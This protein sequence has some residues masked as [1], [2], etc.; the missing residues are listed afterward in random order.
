VPPSAGDVITMSGATLSI[1]NGP[2][3]MP[4]VQLPATS[5]TAPDAIMTAAIGRG[6]LRELARRSRART[7]D[8]RSGIADAEHRRLGAS[9]PAG[10]PRQRAVQT[11]LLTPSAETVRGRAGAGS[12]KAGDR[13]DG[14]ARAVDRRDV[15]PTGDRIV[16]GDAPHDPRGDVPAVLAVERGELTSRS[17]AAVSASGCQSGSSSLARL[18]VSRVWALPSAFIT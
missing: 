10:V 11:T 6:R 14:G 5:Q 16:G 4:A 9:T 12:A 8:T 3:S 1:L 7:R 18:L 17:G 15:A 13:P 2:A